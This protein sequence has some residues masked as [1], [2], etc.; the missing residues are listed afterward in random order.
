MSPKFPYIKIIF[1]V[2]S[3][4]FILILKI[5]SAIFKNRDEENIEENVVE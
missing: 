5:I 4:P 1:K 3:F 2:V